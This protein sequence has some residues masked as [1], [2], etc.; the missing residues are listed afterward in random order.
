[1]LIALIFIQLFNII[2]VTVVHY[3]AL[4]ALLI[5][6]LMMVVNVESRKEPYGW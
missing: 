5:I 2:E 1:M 4:A 3:V 6:T